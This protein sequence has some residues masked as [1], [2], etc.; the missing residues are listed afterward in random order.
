MPLILPKMH[1]FT[2]CLSSRTLHTKFIHVYRYSTGVSAVTWSWNTVLCRFVAAYMRLRRTVEVARY[3]HNAHCTM[4]V[5]VVYLQLQCK[6]RRSTTKRYRQRKR[7]GDFHRWFHA[8]STKIGNLWSVFRFHMRVPW[9]QGLKLPQLGGSWVSTQGCHQRR[10]ASPLWATVRK[11]LF[12]QY[13]RKDPHW[14]E[15]KTTKRL[16]G[17]SQRILCQQWIISQHQKLKIVLVTLWKIWKHKR[18]SLRLQ[19][20]TP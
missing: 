20:F 14:I 16:G 3:L 13:H 15:R 1:I 6:L 8:L 7:I 9:F 19:M 18:V 17:R 10:L 12:I 2:S 4:Y 11:G 5:C